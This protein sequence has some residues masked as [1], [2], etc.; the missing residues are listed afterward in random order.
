MLKNYPGKILL[1]GEYS[2]L[3]GSKGL[4]MPYPTVSGK[5]NFNDNNQSNPDQDLK[6]F[7]D[8]CSTEESNI[9]FNWDLFRKDIEKGLIFDSSI[10]K[11]AGLGSSGALIA[12]FYDRYALYKADCNTH[13]IDLNSI[14]DD[15][16]RLESFHHQRSSGIDPLVSWLERPILLKGL[17]DIKVLNQ[18]DGHQQWLEKNNFHIYL[19]P[20]FTQR[21]TSQWVEHFRKKL[22]DVNFSQ[23]FEKQ[24]CPLVNHTMDNFLDMNDQFFEQV[25]NLCTEQSKFMHEFMNLEVLK[26]LLKEIHQESIGLKLCGA[27]GGGYFLLFTHNSKKD[28]NSYLEDKYNLTLIF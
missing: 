6:Q 22:V 16:A 8:F 24:Y 26:N 3:F 27:G 21:K 2:L 1:F 25:L 20:T 12:A 5:W 13:G 14:R 15:L 7:H 18:L 4:V 11:G 10:P 19:V 23:W 9:K 28:F 17:D